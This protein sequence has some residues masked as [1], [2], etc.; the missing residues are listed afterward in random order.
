MNNIYNKPSFYANIISGIIIF[1]I[2]V[3]LLLNYNTIKFSL[4]QKIIL[5]SLMGI[6]ISLHGFG[7]HFLEVHYHYNPLEKIL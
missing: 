6:L 3:V 5:L 4:Y 2:L 1:I 7:H